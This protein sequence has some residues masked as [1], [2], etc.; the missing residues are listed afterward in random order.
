MLKIEKNRDVELLTAGRAGIDF[1]PQ[2]IGDAFKDISV[3]TKTVGGSPANIAQGA[4][5][6]GLKT[7]FLG[8]VS[9]D[10][11]GEYIIDK[12][13]E[14]DIVTDGIVLDKTGARNCLAILEVVSASESGIYE[15]GNTDQYFHGTY[16]YREGTAD[17]LYD[18]DDVNEDIIKNSKALLVSGTAFSMEP[19][20]TAMLHAIDIAKKNNLLIAMDIDYRPFGWNSKEETA[21]CF[22]E[23]LPLCNIVIGNREEFDSIE[24]IEMPN[25][26]D[27]KKSALSLLNK[28]VELVVVKDGANGSIAYTK[29]NEP[30]KCGIIKTKALKTFGSGDAY[31]AG[32]MYGILR[33]KGIKYA[34]E[35]GSACASIALTKAIG[36]GDA[37][38]EFD[39]AEKHRR[40][41]EKEM[42]R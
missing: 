5:L 23:I 32:F 6:L 11:M 25:N 38:P 17:L 22:A 18:K 1:N 24:Y 20:R 42:I 40:E 31:A 15:S 7:G 21:E 8:K 27:N 9:N 34:M 16:L 12:F 14:L 36:C 30:I 13:K 41:N 39:E 26:K 37:M 19:S 28:G 2:R 3:F 35:L 29:E 33:E 4:A 10:G